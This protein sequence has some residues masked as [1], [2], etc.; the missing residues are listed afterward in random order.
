M[1]RRAVIIGAGIGGLSAAAGLHQAG[2][3]V[4]ICERAQ[5][6]EP[7]GAGIGV[8]PN[9]LRALDTIGAGA[10]VRAQAVTQELGIRRSDGRWLTRSSSA[11]LAARFGDPMVLLTRAGLIDVLLGAVPEGALA[12]ATEVT[13]VRQD[14]GGPALVTTSAG[15]LAADLVVAADGIRSLARAA[16]FPGRDALR[17][18]GFTT[19]RVLV[20]QADVP[21]AGRVSGAS[22]GGCAAPAGGGAAGALPMAESWGIGSLFGLMPL[23]DGR[24]YL[25]AAAVASEGETAGDEAAELL[26]RFGRWHDPIPRLL[27]AVRAGQVL[28]HDVEELRAP[29]TAYHAGR[30]ALVGDAAHPMAPNLGQGGSQALEDAVV[31]AAV[32]KDAGPGEVARALGAY[33]GLRVKRGNMIARRSRQLARTSMPAGWLAAAAR[34][35]AAALGGRLIPHAGLRGLAP[36]YDWHPPGQ[37]GSAR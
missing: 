31:L 16:V 24:V 10:A 17:Y 35:A 5:A 32:V 29:L 14:D 21:G 22:G 25:Y 18:A 6:L 4:T 7:I 13:G 8:C 20:G 9:G 11:E 30:L 33:S 23:H 3:D 27:G 26:R 19:W 28:R 2:W 37:A 15:D 34:D 12:L 36:I 1:H